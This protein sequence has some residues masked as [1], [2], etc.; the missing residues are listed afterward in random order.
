MQKRVSEGQ[1]SFAV[2]AL[3][4]RAS[5]QGREAMKSNLGIPLKRFVPICGSEASLRAKT[6][7]AYP[8]T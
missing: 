3:K 6:L 4:T 7:L 2:Q 1:R 5:S 8:P